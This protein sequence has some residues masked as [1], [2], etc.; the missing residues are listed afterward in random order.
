M[1]TKFFKQPAMNIKRKLLVLFSVLFAFLLIECDDD[2]KTNCT[3]AVCTEEFRSIVVSIK[4]ASDN[5]AFV[6]TSFKVTRL[7]DNKD[8]TITD[9]NL[10]DNN[11]YYQ[12]TNDLKLDLFKFRNTEVEFKGYLNNDLV[13]QK[14]LTITSDCCHIS[15]VDGETE[16]LL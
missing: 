11:G 8:I 16:F 1:N 4:H 14:Q 9:D 10:T 6:L 13:I 15:L 2:N 5:T 3:F 7:S 12:I